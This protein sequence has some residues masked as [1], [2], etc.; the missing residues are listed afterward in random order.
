MIYIEGG[1]YYSGEELKHISEAKDRSIAG[2][3][4]K[5]EDQ[6]AAIRQQESELYRAHIDFE[7][8][9]EQQAQSIKDLQFELQEV[10]RLGDGVVREFKMARARIG[11]VKHVFRRVSGYKVMVPVANVVSTPD[12]QEVEIR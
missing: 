6:K 10:K 9:I 11:Q 12:G 1:N 7:S 3:K 5:V 2:L 4:K 8:K